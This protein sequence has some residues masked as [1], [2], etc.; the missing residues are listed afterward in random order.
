MEKDVVRGIDTSTLRWK[1]CRDEALEGDE[2]SDWKMHAVGPNGSSIELQCQLDT[3]NPTCY[4]PDNGLGA[5][6][7]SANCL[8]TIA[9][10]A[11]GIAGATGGIEK[12]VAEKVLV[13]LIP[14]V[15]WSV[16]VAG[17]GQ[18]I[19]QCT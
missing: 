19:A 10:T 18:G 8:Y 4:L 11:A 3:T 7:P 1:V 12:K 9:T 15:G 14:Y 17:V 5:D 2:C 16:T 13:R 6:P